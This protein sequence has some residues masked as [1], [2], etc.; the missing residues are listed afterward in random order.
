MGDE[1]GQAIHAGQDPKI[2]SLMGAGDVGSLPLA[3][4]HE[5]GKLDREGM[6]AA[7]E[8]M[9]AELV[10]KKKRIVVVKRKLVK[11][12]KAELP[13]QAGTG[14]AEAEAEPAEGETED[15]AAPLQPWSPSPQ[16][17]TL[18][19]QDPLVPADDRAIRAQT[20]AGRSGA[21]ARPDAARKRRA[22]A[23]TGGTNRGSGG[24][25]GSLFQ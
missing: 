14:G 7:A 6:E 5:P 22:V 3:I 21:P 15:E 11:K 24:G 20:S 19:E 8:A 10:K 1:E 12:K 18:S 23:N 16:P 2:G 9:G 13:T 25:F 4:M 17:A